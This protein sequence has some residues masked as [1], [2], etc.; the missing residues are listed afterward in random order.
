[1]HR[2]V[3]VEFHVPISPTPDFLIRTHYLAASIERF[4][5]LKPSNYR[6]VVT[7]GGDRVEDLNERC[8]WA[9]LYPLEWRWMDGAVFRETDW[10]GTAIARFR[11]SMTADVGVLLDGD[12]IVCGK[13]DGWVEAVGSGDTLHACYGTAL[14]L[15]FEEFW[16]RYGRGALCLRLGMLEQAREDLTRAHSLQPE[17]PGVGP[18]IA[19]DRSAR[20]L[21]RGAGSNR[22][23]ARMMGSSSHRLV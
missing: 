13:V 16:V 12:V 14:L 4:S 7:V 17:H 11:H 23:C 1:L 6:I 21:R 8:P 3:R 19:G 18:P 20:T 10:Y 2:P 9:K 22:P 5:G 15:G